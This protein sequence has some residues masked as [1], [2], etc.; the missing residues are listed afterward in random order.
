MK[1]PKEERT[2]PG[3]RPTASPWTELRSWDDVADRVSISIG[4]KL[5]MHYPNGG[6]IS[7]IIMNEVLA[8]SPANWGEGIRVHICK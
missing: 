4:I 8:V 5:Y 6:I 7:K 2:L 1:K 3:P